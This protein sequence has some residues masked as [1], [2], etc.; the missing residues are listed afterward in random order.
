MELEGLNRSVVDDG[1]R[2][3]S[4]RGGVGVGGVDEVEAHTAQCHHL[5]FHE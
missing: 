2:L 3:G 5:S 1:R 4:A